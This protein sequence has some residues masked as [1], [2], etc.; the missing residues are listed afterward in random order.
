MCTGGEGLIAWERRYTPRFVSQSSSLTGNGQ[1]KF[2]DASGLHG[3][4]QLDTKPQQESI[5]ESLLQPTP[6]YAAM[7]RTG[8]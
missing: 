3:V 8:D 6:G 5:G 2:I 1:K 4:S 7:V